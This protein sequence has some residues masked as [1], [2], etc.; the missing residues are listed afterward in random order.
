LGWKYHFVTFC[1]CA[2]ASFRAIEASFLAFV[3][4]DTRAVLP[5]SSKGVKMIA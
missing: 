3:T 5:G 4:D 2:K 1:C